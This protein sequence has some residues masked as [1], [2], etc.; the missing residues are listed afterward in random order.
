MAI[1][2]SF[3]LWITQNIDS[4]QRKLDELRDEY[5][6]AATALYT[7]NCT[8]AELRQ[9]NDL[10]LKIADYCYSQGDDEYYF[11]VLLDLHKKL[12]EQLNDC[13][14][15]NSLFRA[16]IIHLARHSMTGLCQVFIARGQWEKA[17]ALQRE[18]LQ[19]ADS[20]N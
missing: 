15:R 20:M 9:F 12:I 2:H 18:F 14:Q 19:Y 5:R 3:S 7:S 10:S 8:L 17:C 4:Y 6:L 13:L 1:P 16:Q 11:I